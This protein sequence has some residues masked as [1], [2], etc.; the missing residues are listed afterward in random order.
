MNLR[1][2][3]KDDF[4]KLEKIYKSMVGEPF[5]AWTENY[6]TIE[7]IEFDHEHGNLYIFENNDEIIGA[8]S[9]EENEDNSSSHCYISRIVIAKNHQGKGL[10]KE[11]VRSLAKILDNKGYE[12]IKLTVSKINIPAFKTYEKLGFEIVGEY[13]EHGVDEYICQAI[14]KNLI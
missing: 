6:P 4:T 5:C 14:V 7:D 2:S 9:V 12:I 13:M 11:M 8:V 3:K 10:A 1:P